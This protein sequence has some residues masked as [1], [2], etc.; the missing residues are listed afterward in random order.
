MEIKEFFESASEVF[1]P[2]P[3]NPELEISN[4]L[5]IRYA[6]GSGWY[7]RVIYQADLLGLVEGHTPV[8]LKGV[9]QR[10][11]NPGVLWADRRRAEAA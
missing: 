8:E 7:G 1:R 4:F 3:N 6:D 2:L 5:R 11:N 10:T 9:I